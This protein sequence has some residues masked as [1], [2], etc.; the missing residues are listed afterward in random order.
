MS[1]TLHQRQ[2]DHGATRL[3]VSSH[4]R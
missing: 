1:E 3:G 4:A 2:S